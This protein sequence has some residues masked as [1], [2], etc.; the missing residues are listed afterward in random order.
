MD[1]DETDIHRSLLK[2]DRIAVVHRSDDTPAPIGQRVRRRCE[3]RHWD[4]GED[5]G[6]EKSAAGESESHRGSLKQKRPR[7]CEAVLITCGK[8]CLRRVQKLLK[9]RRGRFRLNLLHSRDFVGKAFEG[10]LINLAF[11]VGLLGLAGAAVQVADN[12]GD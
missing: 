1:A 4:G 3:G 12:F 9:L 5:A 7:C 8:T 10:L 2:A 11:T 6:Y